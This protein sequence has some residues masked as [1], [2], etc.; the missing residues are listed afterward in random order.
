MKY[1]PSGLT[2]LVLLLLLPVGAQINRDLPE[3]EGVGITEKLGTQLPLD[4][5]FTD[6]TGQTVRLGDY[7]KPGR[8][9]ILTLNYYACPMLCT[10]QLNGLIAGLKEMDWMPGKQFEIVTVSFNPN[11]TT[12]LARLKKQ[13][14]IKEYGRP[15]AAPGWH[16]L[17]G[18]PDSINKLTQAVGFG[19]KW[20]EKS[21]QYLHAA[22]AIICTPAGQVSRY[23]KTVL[24][25]GN[26]LRLSLSEAN[27]GRFRSTID[28]ILLFCYHYDAEAGKY[29][30][31]AMNIMRAGGILTV[32]VLG[33]V[34]GTAWLRES[35]RT[36]RLN[37]ASKE[38]ALHE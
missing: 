17:T 13:N 6:E 27:E 30:L 31:A 34:L 12:T 23:L 15:D 28:E 24:Y 35:R 36:K 7:F 11:E 18:R 4:L 1:L 9:V 25:D 5:P 22:A 2:L 3:L 10:V 21:Q 37:E 26:T 16:F 32:L 33:G 29:T 14:Y 8:P 38:H 20:D 19:Y